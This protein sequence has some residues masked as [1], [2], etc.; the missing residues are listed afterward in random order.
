MGGGVWKGKRYIDAFDQEKIEWTPLTDHLPNLSVGAMAMAP[1]NPDV[2]YIGTGEGFFNIDAVAGTGMFKT[3][4]VGKRGPNWL[5][6]T[7]GT[8][9]R[10]VNRIAVSPDNPDMRSGSHQWWHLS[11]DRWG[12]FIRGSI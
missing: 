5:R 6:L 9:W 7:A 10:Y 8:D 1:S 4:I 2:M 3:T 11:Y 12:D